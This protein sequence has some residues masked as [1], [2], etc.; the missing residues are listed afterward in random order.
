MDAVCHHTM[1]QKKQFSQAFSPYFHPR[2]FGN[3]LEGGRQ[4]IGTSVWAGHK[5]REMSRISKKKKKKVLIQSTST[6]V[7]ILQRFWTGPG[8]SKEDPVTGQR[9]LH[10]GI[11]PGRDN[12][13]EENSFSGEHWS[14]RWCVLTAKL[15][16]AS[17]DIWI[18]LGLVVLRAATGNTTMW[19]CMWKAYHKNTMLGML[20]Y[21]RG[22]YWWLGVNLSSVRALNCI[23]RKEQDSYRIRMPF[24][25]FLQEEDDQR[26]EGLG[27]EEMEPRLISEVNG[28]K[29][30]RQKVSWI[31]PQCSHSR[32]E[33]DVTCR[34]G[35]GWML[36]KT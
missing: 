32:K 5:Q 27:L 3:W 9:A 19:K 36:E 4:K 22:V 16:T 24:T 17:Q 31:L 12:A 28:V 20:R 6:I 23:R 30:P 15:L 29:P 13:R 26:R 18:V 11:Q 21:C 34:G 2:Y 1:M 8:R 33:L 10:P 14:R 35:S 25:G 7:A